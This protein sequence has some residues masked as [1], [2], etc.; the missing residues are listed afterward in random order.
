VE[1]K[2]SP[3]QRWRIVPY[4]FTLQNR[5]DDTCSATVTTSPSQQEA[6]CG[7]PLTTAVNHICH[8]IQLFSDKV[9]DGDHHGAPD[10][11]AEQVPSEEIPEAH[12]RS[13]GHWSRHEARA[14]MNRAKKTV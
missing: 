12:S 7:Y 4:Q 8:P 2:E 3:T 1:F 9:A 11:R 14:V 10:E 5:D 13:T 6:C